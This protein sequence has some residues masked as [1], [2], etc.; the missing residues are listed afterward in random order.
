MVG[1][2]RS[3]I[4]Y[5]AAPFIMYLLSVVK[6]YQEEGQCFLQHNL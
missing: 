6:K 5:A 4:E 3:R 1:N 2:Q